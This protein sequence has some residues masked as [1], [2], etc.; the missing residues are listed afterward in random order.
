MTYLFIISLVVITFVFLLI[1]SYKLKESF[2]L[3]EPTDFALYQGHSLPVQSATT[4][5]HPMYE[6]KLPSVDGTPGGKRSMYMFT[7][8][9]CKPECCKSSSYSC[10]HGCVCL[11]KEQEHMV[12]S[13]GGNSNYDSCIKRY[14]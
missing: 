12:S 7:Y 13:R 6:D 5:Y 9:E 3:Y 1:G 2:S 10:S 4:G 14:E 11:T 8:N